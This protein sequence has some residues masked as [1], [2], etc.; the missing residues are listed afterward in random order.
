MLVQEIT[1]EDI[2]SL[3]VWVRLFTEE[4]ER[5]ILDYRSIL[6]QANLSPLATDLLVKS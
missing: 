5:I 4:C 2:Q 6:N 1:A 3:R